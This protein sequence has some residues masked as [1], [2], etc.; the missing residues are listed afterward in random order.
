MSTILEDSRKSQSLVLPQLD[1]DETEAPLVEP[2]SN[3]PQPEMTWGEH[4]AMGTAVVLPF[5]G[6]IAAF[7]WMWFAGSVGW[8]HLG[9]M[10]GGWI[11]TGLGITVG[12]HRLLTH[13]SFDTYLGVR[14]FWMA[15]GALAIEG[16]PLIWC[17][18]H[19]KHHQNSDK[20][21]DPH[22]P[23][24]EG[25][26]FFNVLRGLIHAHMGWLFK[27][28]WNRKHLDKYVPDLLAEPMLV[29]VDRAYYLWV[30]ATLAIPALI[31][32]LVEQTWE[33]ALLGLLWGGLMRIFL[34]H[35]ITWSINS[36]CHVW[37]S[38][39]F[40]SADGSRNNLVFGIL[41]HG[42]GW[43]NTHHAFPSS[44]RH[45]LRW[46]QFDLSWLVIRMMQICHLAW[47]VR[48]PSKHAQQ[49]KAIRS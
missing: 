38:R 33:G 25:K 5:L 4:I 9:M 35:H 41:G 20:D 11:L 15:M 40:E 34:T 21:G 22:S 10:L 39:D 36:V 45:G 31:G 2:D 6:T 49:A 27:K 47:N 12:F 30:I 46:W 28:P 37:G 48:L 7:V 18:T 19:R 43:H 29:A 32:G 13:R 23:L 24:L 44:A 16:S 26:G 1:A 3:D 14:A 8:L 42:E 17:A